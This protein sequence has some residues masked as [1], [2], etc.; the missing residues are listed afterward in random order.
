MANA[1][2]RA[3]QIQVEAER[4][5]DELEEEEDDNTNLDR[6]RL[7]VNSCRDELIAMRMFEANSTASARLVKIAYLKLYN[8]LKVK[9][10]IDLLY[11]AYAQRGLDD[12][13]QHYHSNGT[14]KM[15]PSPK[16]H[17]SP[18]KQGHR[19]VSPHGPEEDES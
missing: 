15:K 16:K 6:D 9:T 7:R 13:H 18:L 10:A 5:S 4:A 12:H 2:K 11:Q 19:K 17:A 1:L 3:R 14:L 8:R